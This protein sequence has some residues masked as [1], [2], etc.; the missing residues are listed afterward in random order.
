MSVRKKNSDILNSHQPF[1]LVYQFKLLPSESE[2][3]KLAGH[4][5]RKS[6]SI[7]HISVSDE[8]PIKFSTGGLGYQI[9]DSE[10]ERKNQPPKEREKLVL[11]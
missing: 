7:N 8:S 10:A 9:E 1:Q 6:V 11:V 5:S 3:Q 2:P 4:F